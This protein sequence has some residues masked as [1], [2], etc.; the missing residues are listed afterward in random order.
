[1]LRALHL[2]KRLAN[3]R[4][5]MY[6]IL[7]RSNYLHASATH[8]AIFRVVTAKYRHISTVGP[9]NTLSVFSLL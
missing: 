6:V 7:L 2:L 5:F 1:M 4:R 8:V 9:T 3:A